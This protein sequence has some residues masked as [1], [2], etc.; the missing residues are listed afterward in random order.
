MVEEREDRG[1][2]ENIFVRIQGPV[3]KIEELRQRVNNGE[4]ITLLR[5]CKKGVNCHQ[6]IIK[7]M[8]EE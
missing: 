8:I 4:T 5:Y 6:D 7:A 2:L 3:K 1:G